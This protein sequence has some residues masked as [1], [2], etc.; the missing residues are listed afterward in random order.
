MTIVS[1]M[2]VEFPVVMDRW[3]PEDKLMLLDRSRISLRALQGDAWH[4]EKMAKTGRNEKWQL[5]GQY[6]I[7]L[8]NGGEA[9]GI[10]KN[11]S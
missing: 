6:T 7:E 11:L 3:F 4:L 8:R 2:G 5:S 1:D 9:H 10:I